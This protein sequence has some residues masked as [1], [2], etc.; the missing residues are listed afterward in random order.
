MYPYFWSTLGGHCEVQ[1]DS[2]GLLDQVGPGQ[3]GGD[4][5]VLATPVVEE[6]AAFEDL[7]EDFPEEALLDVSK[8]RDCPDRF[9]SQPCPLLQV[10]DGQAMQKVLFAAEELEEHQVC[11]GP[12]GHDAPWCDIKEVLAGSRSIGE[13]PE[14]PH[15]EELGRRSRAI[16]SR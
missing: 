3:C 12:R 8:V 9:R 6:E 14:A 16:D 5:V 15:H 11:L 4:L 2:A 1:D 7:T 13:Q 10:S